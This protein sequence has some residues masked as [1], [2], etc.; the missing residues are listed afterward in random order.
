VHIEAMSFN[1]VGSNSQPLGIRNTSN[2][3]T[4]AAGTAGGFAWSNFVDLESACANANAEPDSLAGY[5][6]NT[7]T[8]GKLKQTQLGTNLPFIWQNGPQPVNGYR[9]AVTNNLPSNL[10]K[11][12]ATTVCSAAIF[13]S[14][15]RWRPLACSVRRTSPSIPTP[16]P[17]PARSRSRSTSS[18]TSASASRRPSPRPKTCWPDDLPQGRRPAA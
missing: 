12:T 11:G 8:R 6:I 15:C 9:A 16:R 5:A 4:V 7:K 3:G 17:T 10:T 2:I 13:A 1:G 18:T 14:D